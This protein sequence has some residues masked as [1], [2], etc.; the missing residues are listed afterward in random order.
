MIKV[1][2]HSEGLW[3]WGGGV[4]FLKFYLAILNQLEHI[5]T[6]VTIPYD[7]FDQKLIRNVKDCIKK[8]IGLPIYKR[9]NYGTFWIDYPNIQIQMYR[10][11]STP[12]CLKEAD[13]VFLSMSP[14]EGVNSSRVIGYIP[15]LQHVYFPQ[16][17]TKKEIDIR[18]RQFSEMMEKCGT[19]FV[20]SQ[21]TQ[22]DLK[23]CY[24]VQS[25]K[26]NFF[27][28]IFL[29]LANDFSALDANIEKYKLPKRYFMFSN[30]LWVHKDLPTALRAMALLVQ[31]EQYKDVELVCSG[32][33]YDYRNPGYFGQIERLIQDLGIQKSVRFLGFIPKNEQLLILR[34]CVSVI[35]TT[36]FEG[37]AGGGAT[38]DAIAYG[39]SAI[40]SDIEIN[41]EAKNERISFF[42]VGD[43]KDLCMKMKERLMNP[44]K[45]LSITILEKQREVNN[46]QAC[47][48]IDKLITDV[49]QNSGKHSRYSHCSL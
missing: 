39:S 7:Q 32:S 36:L 24:P 9:H 46:R 45:P 22:N 12:S 43:S 25:V 23:K 42:K 28:M 14:V 21:H 8:S 6:I 38:Y 40:I 35:Q 30:Q 13:V 29:P 1:V 11:G 10:R 37:G 18:N 26:C 5:T 16:F 47:F 15:D 4:D 34:H 17:F 49:A 44:L 20:N 19:I 27:S 31:D 2:V 3:G 41:L 48:D 33:T